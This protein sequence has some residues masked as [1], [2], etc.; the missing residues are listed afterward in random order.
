MPNISE[1]AERGPAYVQRQTGRSNERP[2]LP[3]GR[4]KA[5][6]PLPT[7]TS[8]YSLISQELQRRSQ[9]DPAT[10][11]EVVDRRLLQPE[12]FKDSLAFSHT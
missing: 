4:P 10:F 3:A 5:A 9:Q 8:R 11:V 2:L 6:V 12:L 1:I 7:T